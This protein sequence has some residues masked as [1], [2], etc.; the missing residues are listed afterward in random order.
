V[1]ATVVVEEG[2]AEVEAVDEDV[3]GDA[4]HAGVDG[5]EA[6]DGASFRAGD[7]G[8]GDAFV[9]ELVEQGGEDVLRLRIVAGE[10]VALGGLQDVQRAAAGVGAHGEVHR[11]QVAHGVEAQHGGVDPAIDGD[12]GGAEGI[13]GMEVGAGVRRECGVGSLR[14][15]CGVGDDGGRGR[16]GRGD[17]LGRG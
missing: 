8:A 9:G 13:R 1:G 6:V 12:V 14:G 10:D 5:L 16:L 11:V 15:W 2:L 4:H 3:A 7:G 17:G